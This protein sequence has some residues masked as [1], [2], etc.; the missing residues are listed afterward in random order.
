M[1]KLKMNLRTSVQNIKKYTGFSSPFLSKHLPHDIFPK[2][3]SFKGFFALAMN[4]GEIQVWMN[5]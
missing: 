4:G 2:N 5:T 1:R 3:K